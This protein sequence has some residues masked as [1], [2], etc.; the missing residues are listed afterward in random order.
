[1]LREWRIEFNQFLLLLAIGGGGGWMLGYPGV[2]FA[3]ISVP[4]C[5]W[6]LFRIKDMSRWLKSGGW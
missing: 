6:L 1:M 3:L 2:G 5:L 4:Y